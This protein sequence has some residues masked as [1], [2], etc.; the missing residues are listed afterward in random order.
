MQSF[1][2]FAFSAYCFEKI[3][4]FSSTNGCKIKYYRIKIRLQWQLCFANTK[5]IVSCRKGKNN[6]FCIGVDIKIQFFRV[7]YHNHTETSFY[8]YLLFYNIDIISTHFCLYNYEGFMQ[9]VRG[10]CLN[11]L[12]MIIKWAFPQ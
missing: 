9:L 3:L 4:Q 12:F 7:S 2:Y 6:V 10:V 11:C 5:T 1:G 8:I